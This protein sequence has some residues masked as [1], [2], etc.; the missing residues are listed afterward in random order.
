MFFILFFTNSQRQNNGSSNIQ[1]NTE[2]NSTDDENNNNNSVPSNNNTNSSREESSNQSNDQ[3]TDYQTP[4]PQN[5]FS[6][7]KDNLNG[8]VIGYPKGWSVNTSDNYKIL[9]IESSNKQD[10]INIQRQRE[11]QV[12]SN[13]RGNHTKTI[14]TPD[15]EIKIYSNNNRYVSVVK[16]KKE[17]KVRGPYVTTFECYTQSNRTNQENV[18]LIQDISYQQLYQVT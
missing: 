4:K 16:M 10:K 18:N 2:T 9:S 6:F 1:S 17:K 12:L 7:F 5:D 3:N 14:Q 8:R 13:V 11:T 15:S